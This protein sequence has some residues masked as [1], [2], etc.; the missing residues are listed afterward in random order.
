MT[1]PDGKQYDGEWKLGKMHGI[2][3]YTDSKGK[4]GVYVWEDGARKAK[5][6]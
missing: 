4:S 5:Y 3:R 2:G 6:E 1:W